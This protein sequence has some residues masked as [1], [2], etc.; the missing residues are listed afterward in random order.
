MTADPGHRVVR[1]V[2]AAY[3]N[4]KGVEDCRIIA[5]MFGGG[6]ARVAMTFRTLFERHHIRVVP[7]QWGDAVSIYGPETAPMLIGCEYGPDGIMHYIRVHQR[8]VPSRAL[9]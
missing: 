3:R 9:P 5:R 7:E 4:M 1:A 6:R 8:D 2:N